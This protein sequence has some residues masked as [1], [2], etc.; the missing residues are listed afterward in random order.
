MDKLD[1]TV[2]GMRCAGCSANLQRKISVLAGIKN[3]SVNIA[4]NTM[5]L[6]CDPEKITVQEILSTVKKA[7]FQAELINNSTNNFTEAEEESKG[8]FLRFLIAGIFSIFLSWTSMHEMFHLPWFHIA[9]GWDILLQIIFLLPILWAGSNFYKKGFPALLRGT[10]NMDTLIAISTSSAIIYSI[11]SLFGKE[12]EHLY[13]DTAGMIIFLI[14]LGK[15]LEARS[16]GAAS[17]AIRELMK[18][19]PETALLVLEDGTTKN[20]KAEDLKPGD[21][22]RI[23]PGTKIPVDGVIMEGSGSVNESMLTG[24]SMPVEKKTGD[25]VTGGSIVHNGSFLFKADRT[26]KETTLAGI[27]ELVRTAQATKPRIA[28]VADIISGYFV[29]GVILIALLTFCIW[30]FTTGA[31]FG[32]AL[33]FSLA[34]LVIACPCALGLATPTA[35]I[36]GIGRGA[37]LGI[38]FRSG[39]ALEIAGKIDTAIFDKTGTLTSGVPSVD[40]MIPVEC[41]ELSA[42]E[43]ISFAGSVAEKSLHPLSKAIVRYRVM[44]NLP[45]FS[46]ENFS[47]SPGFGISAEINGKQFLL[48]NRAM[49]E[50]YQ[51]SQPDLPLPDGQPFVLAAIEKKLCGVFLFTDPIRPESERAIRKLSEINIRPII[52]SGDNPSSVRT[53]AERIGIDLFFA[54]LLPQEKWNTIREFRQKGKKV[55]MIGDGIND[56]PSLA[57][58]DIG[59]SFSSGTGIA[60]ESA[61]IV[62][63]RPDLLGVPGAIGLSRAAMRIIRQNLFWAFIYN[64]VCIPLAAGIFYPWF[65]WQLSPIAGAAAMAFSSVTVVCN[66]LRLYRWNK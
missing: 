59:I 2:K 19:T 48:G 25:R 10:P 61:Q 52:L 55:A 6:E 62:L 44:K 13:F 60:M 34:V 65:H 32:K 46:A 20:V 15:L 18:L 22:I 56:A 50:K 35:V 33:E 30:F 53:V 47:E 40:S 4:T 41:N 1:F 12:F 37:K 36:A 63:M 66:A 51:I 9:K 16:K 3:C 31:G 11:C 14:M 24:E 42:D 8:Y 49:M 45:L 39:E 64:I 17:G 26:G 38:L 57:A 27:I 28:R 21:I 29:W 5:S 58:A 7:G 23:A 43:V 54:G